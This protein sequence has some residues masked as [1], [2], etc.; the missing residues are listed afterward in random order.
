[1]MKVFA[2]RNRHAR[3]KRWSNIVSKMLVLVLTVVFLMGAGLHP[4]D[5]DKA[6][7]SGI[8]SWT[9]HMGDARDAEH[10]LDKRSHLSE[11][12]S[13]R[14]HTRSITDQ[15]ANAAVAAKESVPSSSKVVYLT[16]DDG[17]S[18]HT[19]DVLDILKRE[20]VKATFFVL[21]KQ[22]KQNPELLKRID[23]EGHA[24]GNHS[25]NHAY[26]KLYSDFRNFWQQIRDTGQAIKEVVGYEPRLVRA[27]GGT[28][29]NFDKQY[30]QLLSQAG[31]IVH[32]WHVDSGDSK[33]ANVPKSEIMKSIRAGARLPHTVVLMH[34]SAGHGET[35]KALPDMIQFYRD[36][37][38]TFDIM[39]PDLEPVQ[40]KVATRKRW[41]RK[42]V[43]QAWIDQHVQAVDVR[44][45]KQPERQTEQRP[46]KRAEQQPQKHF[47]YQNE[48]TM[49]FKA[50]TEV[51]ML[52]LQPGQYK[53]IQQNTYIP[54][55]ILTTHLDGE[56][57][58]S[59]HSSPIE[60]HFKQGT[61][62]VNRM[63]GAVVW[64]AGTN[65]RERLAWKGIEEDGVLWIPLR[66]VLDTIDISLLKHEFIPL[67]LGKID[68]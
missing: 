4:I 42:P 33:R 3:R 27:P 49:R 1:M 54:A 22:V 46:E 11:R 45:E 63:T 10:L 56:I 59:D 53:R 60:L 24:I 44:G 47:D 20:K 9:E 68:A 12:E 58:I 51:G 40:F 34:D 23:A 21:G 14:I 50:T 26:K 62:T 38:Y 7:G 61:I 13:A 8:Q 66:P 65:E 55:R 17:P 57:I 2:R 15:F 5:G 30:F 52:N 28:Y 6:E 16:F 32:D 43:S 29:L 31:Y 19:A 64:Q 35:V 41:E 37:G 48:S 39:T 25:Y 36:K 67:E 18:K